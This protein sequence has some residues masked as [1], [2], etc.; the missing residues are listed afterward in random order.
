LLSNSSILVTGG[1][2]SFGKA[3][4]ASLLNK[5]DKPRRIVVFSRDELKQW[6]MRQKFPEDQYPELRFFIGDI[7]DRDRLRRAC[8]D[9]DYIIHS[10]AM[11]QV[12]ASE[13]NPMECIKTNIIGAENVIEA[14]LDNKVKKIIALS[15]DKAAAPINIYGASK[16]CSDK[17]F[18]AANNIVGSRDL[19]ISI[20]RY[21]NVMGS[22]GSVIPLF[23]RLAKTGVLP[24]TH[25]EMTRF[26]ITIKE[27][28]G[29][30]L[31]SLN[32][33]FG[34][35]IVVPKI[36]S[37]RI[38]D[39]AKAIGP[40]C[41]QN[42]I[43]LRPGEKLHEKLITVSDSLTTYDIGNYYLILPQSQSSDLYISHYNL[44]NLNLLKVEEN[45]T[46]DS[47]KNSIFLSDL[48]IRN[49]IKLN[50]KDDFEPI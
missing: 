50:I 43:G 39:V 49:L 34:G 22:R 11:K 21:G 17:L 37:Y 25:T 10:A 28:V 44:L 45:F 30:V 40:N 13:Y 6:N 46:Y 5:K 8:E 36:S 4:I 20:V 41:K 31:W 48:E 14:A 29:L 35:E 15:T 33:T 32:N 7:R 27:G 1:T 38:L 19:S 9:I 23:M 3:F 42:I 2:G 12:P 26:N 18:I 47:G 24:I 16:L